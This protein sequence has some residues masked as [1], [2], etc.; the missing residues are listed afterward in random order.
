MKSRQTAK[1][2]RPLAELLA[3][4]EGPGALFQ[5]AQRLSRLEDGLRALLPPGMGAHVRLAPGRD[6]TIV[7][8][9]SNS[10]LAA[11]LRQQAPSLLEALRQRGWAIETLRIRVSLEQPPASPRPGKTAHLGA[12]GIASFAALR[13]AL[14]PSPLRDALERL[15]RHHTEDSG[16]DGGGNTR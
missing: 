4:P 12:G 1:P 9:V 16:K 2:V 10:A 11:R 7:L 15:V 5:A 8:L 3:A 14:P 6:Q 13:D